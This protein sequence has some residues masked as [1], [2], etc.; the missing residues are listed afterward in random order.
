VKGEVQAGSENEARVKLRAQKLMPM[1]L[2]AKTA[3]DSTQTKATKKKA[4]AGG[5]I[6]GGVKPKELQVFTRQF[7]VLIASGVPVVQSLEAMIGPG[8][9]PNMNHALKSILGEVAK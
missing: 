1:K 6:G 7:A 4:S 8:R 5:S 2:V 3:L 9:S